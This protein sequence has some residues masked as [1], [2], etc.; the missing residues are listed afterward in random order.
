MIAQKPYVVI[1]IDSTLVYT[2]GRNQAILES[3][4]QQFQK[5]YPDDCQQLGKV[6][7][8]PGDYGYFSALD[9]GQVQFS[10]KES[11]EALQKFWRQCFFSNDYLQHDT[12]TPGAK[13][14][15]LNLQK[16]QIPFGFL[17]G[18][19]KG[20]MWEGTKA[21][22]EQHGFPY[23]ED[24]LILKEDPQEKDELYKSRV[25]SDLKKEHNQI[26]LIDNEPVILHQMIE[27]HPDIKLVW[28]DCCHS[29]K[30]QP[31]E[32]IPHIKDFL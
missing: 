6:Q 28:F 7:C 16:S 24:R 17:T 32:N 5:L 9:R 27:D 19:Y 29:G 21:S 15:L 22:F 30:K 12:P 11:E 31:P 18:R 14:F 10:S 4:T 23:Q 20:T 8:Q 2:H 3:F 13:D 1:D 25:M 26:W